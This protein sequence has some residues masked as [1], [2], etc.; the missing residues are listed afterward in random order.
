MRSS[1][2]RLLARVGF[3]A[4]SLLMVVGLCLFM[5]LPVVSLW[6]YA[7]SVLVFSIL[8]LR[9]ECPSQRIVVRRLRGQQ[10]LGCLCLLL[11][12]V[13]RS[14]QVYAYGPFRRNEWMVALAI[15]CVLLLYAAWRLP[16]ELEKE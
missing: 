8:L 5:V 4:S 9:E 11:V 14:M 15:G 2:S 6:V 13:G 3:Y 16:A 7:A 12:A 10:L 1:Q